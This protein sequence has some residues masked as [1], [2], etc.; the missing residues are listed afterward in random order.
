MIKKN[1]N[2]ENI[3]NREELKINIATKLLEKIP[4]TEKDWLYH[5][6]LI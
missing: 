5:F 6:L 3:E 4:Q 2:D 1:I